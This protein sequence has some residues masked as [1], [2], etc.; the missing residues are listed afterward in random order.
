VGD[1]GLSQPQRSE[2]MHSYIFSN[3]EY[4]VGVWAGGTFNR[5]FRV[6]NLAQAMVAVNYLNGGH[7]NYND[8]EIL[9]EY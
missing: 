3:N 4:V 8:F 7:Y 2:V 9:E 5:I 1:L 6:L